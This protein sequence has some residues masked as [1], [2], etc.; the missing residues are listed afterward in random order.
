MYSVRKHKPVYLTFMEC[1]GDLEGNKTVEQIIHQ[2]S[3]S[4]STPYHEHKIANPQ[5]FIDS[6]YVL[7]EDF[8]I[9]K[10]DLR[11]KETYLTSNIRSLKNR[12]EI[13]VKNKVFEK[14]ADEF[15][16]KVKENEF[17]V[18]QIVALFVTVSVF[19]LNSVKFFTETNDLYGYLSLLSG[20]AACLVLFNAI[21]KWLVT[22]G[23]HKN[24]LPKNSVIDKT[25]KMIIDHKTGKSLITILIL[26]VLVI[27]TFLLFM[28]NQGV[29]VLLQWFMNIDII[30]Y[31]A[32]S[33]LITFVFTI[34][35]FYSKFKNKINEN[36]TK[37]FFGGLYDIY[38]KFIQPNLI[39]I[40]AL[41][42][43]IL[44]TLFDPLMIFIIFFSMLA[45][46]S[47]VKH[48]ENKKSVRE[49]T[50]ENRLDS[51]IRSK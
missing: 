29:I 44:A 13:D 20:L 15:E 10:D 42:I 3:D 19:V 1:V 16:K 47:S 26:V 14:K 50:I 40:E 30:Q 39:R 32:F 24:V 9:A 18:I 34:L 25:L 4:L 8:S 35:Y 12:V 2:R 48:Y 33:L 6:A 28:G 11:G 51:L 46:Y 17:K 36:D 7:P 41:I 23:I 43:R 27:L 49:K 5:L 31:I 21:F 45:Y 38:E 37:Q 22:W